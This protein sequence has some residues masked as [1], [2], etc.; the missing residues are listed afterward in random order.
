M[1]RIGPIYDLLGIRLQDLNAGC[2]TCGKRLA[3]VIS[4]LTGEWNV[5]QVVCIDCGTVA[6]T[7]EEKAWTVEA[8]W[9]APGLRVAVCQLCRYTST[10]ADL[11]TAARFAQ[12][13]QDAKHSQ[14]AS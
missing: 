7:I 13:H 10:P 12:E 3:E 5:G 2:G 8:S 14:V 1:T 9:R 11:A 4:D 6:P